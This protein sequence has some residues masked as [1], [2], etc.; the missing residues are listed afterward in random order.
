MI[1]EVQPIVARWKEFG[2]ALKL[3]DEDF[4]KLAKEKSDGEC[5][6]EVV[7]SWFGKINIGLQHPLPW[8]VIVDAVASGTG[9]NHR[10]LAQDIIARKHNGIVRQ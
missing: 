8:K 3:T 9:G 6:E 2:K 10:D 4:E 5:L 1:A 7:R